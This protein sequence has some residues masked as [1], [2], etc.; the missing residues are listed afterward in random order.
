MIGLLNV[1]KITKDTNLLFYAKKITE[2][3]IKLFFDGKKLT[4]RLNNSY[5]PII[6]D[7]EEG[8]VK[9]STIPGPYHCKLSIGLLELS[10]LTNDNKYAQVS[11]SLCD[12]ARR[13]QKSNGQFITNP[14]SDITYLHPHHLFLLKECFLTL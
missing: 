6:K 3:L 14:E 10:R 9:W 5:E 1:Y 8:I 4:A 7:H 12:Y 2:A 11:D 13:L